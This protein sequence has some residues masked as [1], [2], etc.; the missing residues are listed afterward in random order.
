MGI[1]SIKC[2]D[3]HNFGFVKAPKIIMIINSLFN[4]ENGEV[5]GKNGKIIIKKQLENKG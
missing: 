4:S 5:A 3:F 1:V 2:N